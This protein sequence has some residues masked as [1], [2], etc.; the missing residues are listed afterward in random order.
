MIF[1]AYAPRADG[2]EPLGTTDKILRNDLKSSK[3]FI[4]NAIRILGKGCVVISNSGNFYR[5]NDNKI[6][7]DGR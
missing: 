7:Y 3:S 2:S 4:R 5:E 6:I 1:Y